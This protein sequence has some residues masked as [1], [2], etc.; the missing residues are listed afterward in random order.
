LRSHAQKMTIAAGALSSP[1]SHRQPAKEPRRGSAKRAAAIAA[2]EVLLTDLGL[3]VCATE[4]G[5]QLGG[6]AV[7]VPHPPRRVGYPRQGR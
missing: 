4:H 5:K 7:R 1:W 2:I 6:R 3:D